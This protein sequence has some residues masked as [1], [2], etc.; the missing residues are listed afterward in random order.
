MGAGKGVGFNV[1]VPLNETGLEDEDYMGIVHALLLPIA[2]E[3]SIYVVI[4]LRVVICTKKLKYAPKTSKICNKSFK[5]CFQNIKNMYFKKW[6][7]YAF[8]YVHI[9]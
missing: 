4:R 1:N 7:K 3:A 5:I 6:E 2:Y 9:L 8:A